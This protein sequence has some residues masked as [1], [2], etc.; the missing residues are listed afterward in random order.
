MQCTVRGQPE[1]QITLGAERA[2]LAPLF[3]CGLVRHN[4]V[5]AW[6]AGE[7]HEMGADCLGGAWMMQATGGGVVLLPETMALFA[8]LAYRRVV[9]CDLTSALVCCLAERTCGMDGDARRRPT[10][11]PVSAPS[12]DLAQ[13]PNAERWSY[14]TSV[15]QHQPARMD[16]FLTT[17]GVVGTAAYSGYR[18]DQAAAFSLAL[19][20]NPISWPSE[21]R[22][23]PF[24]PSLEY[25]IPHT[26]VPN[27]AYN[28]NQLSPLWQPTA[29]RPAVVAA[30]RFQGEPADAGTAPALPAP[31]V[32]SNTQAIDQPSP[33][34][35]STELDDQH[36]VASTS[37]MPQASEAPD[38]ATAPIDMAE[39][40]EKYQT[41]IKE[42]FTNIQNGVL[43]SASESLLTVSDWLLSKVVELGLTADNPELHQARVQ[44][45]QN[46]NHA[47][48]ALLQKQK[49]MVGSGMAL[50]RDQTLVSEDGLKEMGKEIVRL[51]DGIKRHGLV[52]YDDL[53]VLADL[54]PVLTECLDFYENAAGSGDTS[55]AN[56]SA[57]T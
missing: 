15:S 42:I 40:Y 30:S 19:P 20:P 28:T 24:N 45:W 12:S 5:L 46:F 50:Q 37:G 6:A 17:Q 26:S 33:M 32:S 54:K 22:Q 13:D 10:G 11:P 36:S 44:L 7:H 25:G 56:P 2:R 41:T 35:E 29:R 14:A 57:S 8:P 51:C 47:W 48:L 34:T 16:M 1:Q 39:A 23:T 27:T 4:A 3:P 38:T 21:Y 31:A 18:Q 53:G 52:D 43:G 49:D 55:I 9:F